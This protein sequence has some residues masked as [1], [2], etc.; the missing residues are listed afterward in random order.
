MR[1]LNCLV[2]AGLFLMGHGT[3]LFASPPNDNFD[4][5]QVLVGFPVSFEDRNEGATLEVGEPLPDDFSPLNSVW[6]EWTAPTNGWVQI[7][8]FDSYYCL[9]YDEE[10]ETCF[11]ADYDSFNPYVAVWSGDNLGELTEIKNSGSKQSR[12]INVVSGL[13]YRIAVYGNPNVYE[14]GDIILNI[15]ADTSSRI[16]GTVTGPDATTP[17]QGI[18]VQASRWSEYYWED[19]VWSFTDSLGNYTI[20]GLSED[21]Y[22]I[23][24]I[25]WENRAQPVYTTEY[26]DNSPTIV[27]ADDIMIAPNSTVSNINASLAAS[28]SISGTVT[29]QD[30]LTPLEYIDVDAYTWNEMGEYWDWALQ[31]AITDAAGHYTIAG[32]PAGVYR[33]RFNFYGIEDYVW[34]VYSNAYDFGSGTDIEVDAGELLSGIDISLPAASQIAGTVYEVDVATPIASIIVELYRWSGV[35]WTQFGWSEWT[36]GLGTYGFGRLP[37]GIYKIKFS[38]SPYGDDDYYSAWYEN[39]TTLETASEIVINSATNLI[40]VDIALAVA[41]PEIIDVQ[42]NDDGTEFFFNGVVG[43]DYILQVGD[44]LGNS[45]LDVGEAVNA[46]IDSNVLNSDGVI[47]QGIWRIRRDYS[48]GFD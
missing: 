38:S 16:T 14:F 21:T 39:A 30:G 20:R 48:S 23:A 15:S 25:D 12:Y 10:S 13:V 32:L 33:L 2:V 45:W 24:F 46:T 36:S 5:P 19:F 9:F 40:D 4:S 3:T 17:L 44:L 27:D 43:R 37:V 42:V 31:T 11:F 7:D 41:K 22:R 34:L 28:A 29:A 8:T 26:Y 1:R 6:Y 18:K 47:T 35:E